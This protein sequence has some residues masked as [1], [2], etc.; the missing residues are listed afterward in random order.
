MGA[1]TSRYPPHQG[2]P[3]SRVVQVRES[4]SQVTPRCRRKGGGSEDSS[5]VVVLV[6]HRGPDALAPVVVED[7]P[8][9]GASQVHS[10]EDRDTV[11]VDAHHPGGT[12]QSTDRRTRP[13]PPGCGRG[14]SSLPRGVVPRGR[15][16]GNRLSDPGERI[17]PV[18]GRLGSVYRVSR[19]DAWVQ[20]HRGTPPTHLGLGRHFGGYR[21]VT[22]TDSRP[23][24][25][26][27]L[28][29]DLLRPPS[30][31]PTNPSRPNLLDQVCPLH[32]RCLL[33]RPSVPWDPRVSTG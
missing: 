19:G 16:A 9:D 23:P 14:P 5:G 10:P 18:P 27:Q 22:P 32:V 21:T 6:G 11:L 4:H 3:P 26:S 7:A 15:G 24:R 20:V 31:F 28:G 33:S 12:G 1:R 29:I 30:Q 8:E 25:S 13:S 2:T 17:G